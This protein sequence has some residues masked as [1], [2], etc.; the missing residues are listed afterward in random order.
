MKFVLSGLVVLLVTGPLYAQDPPENEHFE[1]NRI[2]DEARYSATIVVED[3]TPSDPHLIDE[4]PAFVTTIKLDPDQPRFRTLSEILGQTVGVTV[5]DFGGLGKL[6]TVSIRG[7]SANQV[8]VLL[9]GVKLNTA[10]DSGVDLSNIPLDNIERIEVLRGA[11]SAVFG[12]GAIGGV[13]NLISRKSDSEASRYSAG[14]TYGSFATLESH[15]G[16]SFKSSFLQLRFDGGYRR[17]D[18]DFTFTNENGTAQNPD[19]DFE[20]VR[21]NNDLEAFNGHLWLFTPYFSSLDITAH[22]DG[23]YAEKGIPGIVTFP[24][25]HAEQ[26]DRRITSTVRFDLTDGVLPAGTL[27]AELRFSYQG[28][29]FEDPLGEQTGFPVYTRQRTGSYNGKLGYRLFHGSGEGSIQVEWEG[30]R[31][32][33][34]E[35]GSRDRRDLGLALRHDWE[36]LRDK[37]WITAMVRYDDVSHVG[38]HIS[39]KAGIRWFITPKLSVKINAGGAFRSPSFNELYM[40]MGFITGNPDLR[41]EESTSYDLGLVWEGYRYRLEAALF[42]SDADDLIQYVLVSGFRYQPYNIGKARSRGLE[43]DTQWKIW[44]D[45]NIAAAYT[46]LD[47]VDRTDD[48]NYRNKQIPG[49]PVH[50]LFSRLSWDSDRF[51]L[52]TEWRYISGNYLT[53]ANTKRLDNRQTGNVGMVAKLTRRLQAGFEVKNVTDNQVTDIRGFPLPPRTFLASLKFRM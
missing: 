20:D 40:N 14:L 18:G 44:R 35:F 25:D 37:F 49:R 53:R 5:K 31:L 19:D 27:S 48:R 39:P 28:L 52:F 13:V 30:Q 12:D 2:E 47:A 45:L 38:D 4:I 32:N 3:E 9:D 1:Y 29:N 10:S 17:S 11:D 34:K 24:S 21:I 8:L 22:F 36:M 42:Q 46:Y 43:C 41:P 6:S 16:G 51:T 33:D 50:D 15:L 23:Y 7:A 26:I